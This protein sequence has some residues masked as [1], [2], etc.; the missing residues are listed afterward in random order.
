MH[1]HDK[2]PHHNNVR[3]VLRCLS[4]Q[5]FPISSYYSVWRKPHLYL[6]LKSTEGKYASIKLSATIHG[7]HGQGISLI[8]AYNAIPR[9]I[10]V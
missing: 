4:V 7:L 10:G 8:P 5:I 2:V 1:H 3:L 6:E 9:C